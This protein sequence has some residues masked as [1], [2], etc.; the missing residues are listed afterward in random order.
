MLAAVSLQ[1]VLVAQQDVLPRI[2]K[3]VMFAFYHIISL[4]SEP[5]YD[6]SI[7]KLNPSLGSLWVNVALNT[8]EPWWPS[9]G[10][11]LIHG[12]GGHLWP[13]ATWKSS[14]MLALKFW[15][16][17]PTVEPSM[18]RLD[19]FRFSSFCLYLCKICTNC[20]ILKSSKN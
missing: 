17:H 8:T 19:I 11:M 20:T 6:S 16:N 9:A 15:F 13:H 3:I 10:K 18:R 5:C 14:P 12:R 7:I 2:S 4:N 1:D